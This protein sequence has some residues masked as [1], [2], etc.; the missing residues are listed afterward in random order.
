M[1]GI[2][3][4]KQTRLGNKQIATPPQDQVFTIGYATILTKHRY[5]AAVACTR[6]E[7]NPGQPDSSVLLG[8]I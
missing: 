4:R 2:R 6:P 7:A 3:R 1:N 5:R 8:M